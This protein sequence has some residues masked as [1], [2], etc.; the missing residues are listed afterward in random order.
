MA[1]DDFPVTDKDQAERGK[2]GFLSEITY[3]FNW[4]QLI[5]FLVIVAYFG[6]L[7]NT[8][9]PT[10]NLDPKTNKYHWLTETDQPVPKGIYSEGHM[11][12]GMVMVLF[13]FFLLFQDNVNRPLTLAQTRDVGVREM[14][15]WSKKYLHTEFLGV[16]Q[17]H[18][19][20]VRHKVDK[21]GI[22]RVRDHIQG[23][24][25]KT[26]HGN[27]Y[28]AVQ[29]S[30]MSPT[31]G[32]VMQILNLNGFPLSTNNAFLNDIEVRTGEDLKIFGAIRKELRGGT[33]GR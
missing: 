30:P 3:R 8:L 15:E 22:L 6:Y 5:A 19:G 12:I 13:L 11:I 1:D 20:R 33:G 10:S 21:Q 23:M 4:A 29:I 26:R 17:P 25:V 32:Y 14:T 16:V 27:E 18:G 7:F 28:F 24:T 31:K 9:G 2:G